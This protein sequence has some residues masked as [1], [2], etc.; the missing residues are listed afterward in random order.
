MA[1]A[2]YIQWDDDD[3]RFVLDQHA[4]LGLY[5]VSLLT[6]QSAH[7]HVAPIGHIIPRFRSYSLMLHA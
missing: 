4:A 2:C 6:Q 1:R 5:S 7:G 3:V